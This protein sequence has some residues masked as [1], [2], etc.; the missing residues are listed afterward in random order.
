MT[1]RY[2]MNGAADGNITEAAYWCAEL[3]SGQMSELDDAR[4]KAWLDKDPQNRL[5]LAECE[6]IW[7]MSASLAGDEE[8]LKYLEPEPGEISGVGAP[9]KARKFLRPALLAASILL[10]GLVTWFMQAGLY[11][12]P[13]YST[14]VGEQRTVVL[15][16]DS[17]IHLNT[18]TRVK[19][20][21]GEKLRLITLE[22]G[23]ATFEVAHSTVR[24]FEVVAGP[25]IVRA[26]GTV[27]NVR[28]DGAKVTVTVLE[29]RVQ[30]NQ[31][32]V[33]ETAPRQP[34]PEIAIGQQLSYSTTGIISEIHL[35]NIQRIESWQQGKL[36]LDSATL[37]EAVQEMNRYSRVKLMIGDEKLNRIHISGVFNVGDVKSMIAGLTATLPVRAVY[38]PDKII[39]LYGKDDQVPRT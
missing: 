22:R 5:D 38:G 31:Q 1:G 15:A 28:A 4:H 26:V 2:P 21:Y 32:S 23:E 12:S 10:V 16:D 13:Y 20:E 33:S 37:A 17:R 25:G 34:A 30:V 8:I 27:F 7:E 36:D 29:G 19:V 11:N 39:L 35:A 14:D 18:N 9:L 6:A 24:P 3:K